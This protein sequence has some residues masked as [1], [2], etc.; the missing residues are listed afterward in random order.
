MPTAARTRLR[1]DDGFTLVEILVV[2]VIVGILS[3]IALPSFLDQRVKAQDAEAKVYLVA[4]G[5]ALEIWHQE[6]DTY[7][8]AG[9][10]EL[11]RID[12]ALGEARNM[13]VDGGGGTFDVS[14]DS[15]AGAR[16]GG[17]F[18]LSRLD[19]DRLVRS[20]ANAG[21]GACSAS[22]EW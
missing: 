10:A 3:A 18:T 12:P 1:H 15:A 5:K 14:I 11:A 19:G 6:R 21:K 22:N 4:A 9:Q 20:C 8:G 7:A 13:A 17:R 16:G 2:L